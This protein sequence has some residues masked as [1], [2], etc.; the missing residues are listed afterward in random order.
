MLIAIRT[1]DTCFRR[2]TTAARARGRNHEKRHAGFTTVR[3]LRCLSTDTFDVAHF[4]ST[5][6]LP[7]GLSAKM[8]AVPVSS[9]GF[10]TPPPHSGAIVWL[11]GL[12]GAGKSTLARILHDRLDA[13]G[14]KVSVLDGEDVRRSLWREL[15]YS[16]VDRDDNVAR[17]ATVAAL[18][19]RHDVVVLVAAIAPYAEARREARRRA[20]AD[21]L[22]FL[23]VFVDAPMEVLVRRDVKGLYRRALSGELPQFTGVSDPYQRPEAPDFTVETA[24][25]G[26]TQSADRI[27]SM[28]V[29]RQL[30]AADD[31]GKPRMD[32]RW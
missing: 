20:E 26:S 7:C 4:F 6:L 11:T 9:G 17:L 30:V 32:T 14:T 31:K 1:P 21:G 5:W 19:A 8:S 13:A 25:E 23:E 2:Y 27:W 12:S 29:L 28:L 24:D 3:R 18:I 10:S 22:L 15:G 16:K